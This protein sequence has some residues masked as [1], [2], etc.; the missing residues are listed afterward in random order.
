MSGK[1]KTLVEPSILY[2][3]KRNGFDLSVVDTSAVYN[4]YA[5]R[6]LRKQA[7]ESLPD[8]IGNF[9]ELSVWIELK[10]P[11]KRRSILQSPHQIAFLERKIKAG[12]FACVTDSVEHLSALWSGYLKAEDRVAFL[13]SDLPRRKSPPLKQQPCH[14]K[15]NPETLK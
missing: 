13:I 15:S 3:A 1:E 8:V 5:G 12:C 10:A 11:Q 9:K 6:Y 14:S 7:S 2:W 4:P